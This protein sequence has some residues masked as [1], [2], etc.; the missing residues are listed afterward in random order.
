MLGLADDVIDFLT[1]LVA[2][3]LIASAVALVIA[4][5]TGNLPHGSGTSSGG[6]FIWIPDA[7]GGLMPIWIPE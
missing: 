2:V 4:A 7:N 5:C 6:Y 1:A 3:I